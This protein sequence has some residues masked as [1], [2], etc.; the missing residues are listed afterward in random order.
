MK[1]ALSVFLVVFLVSLLL[2]ALAGPAEVAAAQGKPVEAQEK[3]VDPG[4]EGR[5]RFQLHSPATMSTQ[6]T[7]Y[8]ECSDGSR[9][10]LDDSPSLIDCTCD[11]A[12]I[13]GETCWG[14]DGHEEAVC[15][16][17]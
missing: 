1:R 3:P 9:Y 17:S 13:C 16:A 12:M 11:C 2:T 4:A 6:D 8:I 5:S 7:C 14:T 15:G 10:V